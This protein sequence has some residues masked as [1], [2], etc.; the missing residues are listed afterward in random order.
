MR[1]DRTFILARRFSAIL[2]TWLTKK[3]MRTIIQRNVADPDPKVCHSHDYC[4]PNEAMIEAL[5]SMG[6]RYRAGNTRVGSL[7]DRAWSLA[8]QE[9]FWI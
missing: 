7:I 2:K 6:I 8:K 1:K 4:D 3:Q 5:D 9:E